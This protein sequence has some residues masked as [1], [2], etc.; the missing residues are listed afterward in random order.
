MNRM[1]DM[2]IFRVTNLE[3]VEY[4][5]QVLYVIVAAA[6]KVA[7]ERSVRY[8]RE[9]IARSGHND[10]GT[11]SHSFKSRVIHSPLGPIFEVYSDLEYSRWV[12]DGTGIYGP[13]GTP[14]VRPGG[15]VMK[16]QPGKKNANSSLRLDHRRAPGSNFNPTFSPDVYAMQVAG[17]PGAHFMEKA[18]ARI[19]IATFIL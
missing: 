12:N 7:G 4:K 1:T 8:V 13:Y 3:L 16:F 17:Q 2:G 9:E 10:S 5:P 19:R 6:S 18:L 15:G 11:L 14:I